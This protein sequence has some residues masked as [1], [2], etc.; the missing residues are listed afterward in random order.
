MRGGVRNCATN[1]WLA[2]AAGKIR[3]A[4]KRRSCPRSDIDNRPDLKTKELTIP[5]NVRVGAVIGRESANIRSLQEIH[6]I[7]CA[8]DGDS[9]KVTLSGDEAGIRG[10]KDDLVKLFSSFNIA[11]STWNFAFRFA[12]IDKPSQRR[13]QPSRCALR[14][15]NPSG[16]WTFERKSVRSSDENVKYHLYRLNQITSVAST[17]VGSNTKSW[18]AVYREPNADSTRESSPKQPVSIKVAFGKLCFKPLSGLLP[19]SS[20]SWQELQKLELYQDFET[21]WSNVCVRAVLSKTSMVSQLEGQMK[22]G[23]DPY[24]TL[25][26][27]Y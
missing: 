4:S 6:G 27:R 7:Q 12:S 20:Q 10:A 22:S 13:S 25:G 2:W 26:F 19:E 1:G 17:S 23:G 11:E 21:R 8:V 24:K 9:R 3:H 15:L 14:V 5:D 18:V 16:M